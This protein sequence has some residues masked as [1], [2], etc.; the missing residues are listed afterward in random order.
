MAADSLI[1]GASGTLSET[2]KGILD[3]VLND[4]HGPVQ[5]T[6]VGGATV[7]QGLG[8]N[9]ETQGALVES[10]APVTGTLT[11]GNFVANVN[12]PANVGLAF[13][14][15]NQLVNGTSV[16][17]YLG[18]LI[19]QALPQN[20]VNTNPVALEFRNSLD[21]AVETVLQGT[22]ASNVVRVVTVTDSSV[23]NSAPQ[24]VQITGTTGSA[25]SSEVVA[26]NMT[27]VHPQ[28][29]VVLENI[30]RTVIVGQGSVRVSG[31]TSSTLV[32]D[33]SNQNFTGGGGGDTLVGGGGFDTLTG[34]QGSDLFGFNSSGHYTI[35]DFNSGTGG[36]SLVFKIPGI[37]SLQQ[38]APFV[39][40]VVVAGGNTTYTFTEGSTITLVGVTPEQLSLDLISF[41]ALNPGN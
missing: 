2:T 8:A 28:N 16:S 14:G 40:N 15:L 36:D 3:S 37:T 34:G 27:N 39:T 12:L 22:G 33:N 26:L 5:T 41:N 24:N 23:N 29:T 13:E 17:N 1:G 30:D 38:L 21:R 6:N 25:G 18:G 11:N 31:N 9:N 20:F 32:G 4:T 7:V 35:S 19:D 10:N